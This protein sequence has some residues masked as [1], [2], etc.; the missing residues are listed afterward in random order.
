MIP[1]YIYIC[2]CVSCVPEYN[3]PRVVNPILSP[4]PPEIEREKKKKKE[5]KINKKGGTTGDEI[6]SSE[7]FQ[8]CVKVGTRGGITGPLGNGPSNNNS[9]QTP[10]TRDLLLTYPLEYVIITQ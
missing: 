6:I 5:R 3:T 8:A 2:V 4:V 9:S 1:I 7:G 10:A